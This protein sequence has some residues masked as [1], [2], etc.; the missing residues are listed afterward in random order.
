MQSIRNFH[1][2]GGYDPI[3]RL[4]AA[5][6]RLTPEFYPYDST[7]ELVL[8]ALVLVA[9]A[10][11]KKR[12]WP[13]LLLGLWM[14]A[15]LT[16]GTYSHKHYY[17]P[18]IQ[19]RYYIPAF[20]FLIAVFGITLSRGVEF[21]R[22]RLRPGR[23][24]RALGG[25]A[26]AVF[27]LIPLFHL[28]GV[29][30]KAGRIYR[31]DFVKLT[32]AAIHDANRQQ[33]DQIVVSRQIASRVGQ[34]WYRGLPR[35]DYAER[36]DNV[37][38]SRDLQTVGIDRLLAGGGFHYIEILREIELSVRSGCVQSFDQLLHPALANR[39]AL[40]A[41][42]PD[43]NPRNVVYLDA[44]TFA[45]TE[46]D[47]LGI[48]GVGRYELVPSLT[49]RQDRVYKTRTKEVAHRLT[50]NQM[51]GR[52]YFAKA[53]A[54]IDTYRV[55]VRP[56]SVESEPVRDLLATTT[57]WQVSEDTA[58]ISRSENGRLDITIDD[59]T[60]DAIL[61][62]PEYG[63]GASQHLELPAR[64]RCR[65]KIDLVVTD[66]LT[67]DCVLVIPTGDDTDEQERPLRIRLQN[68]INEIGL[69]TKGAPRHVT[70]TFEVTGQGTV[71]IKS[72]QSQ[73][74]RI[75]PD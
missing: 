59:E 26:A 28:Q 55:N 27:V 12:S 7:A 33:A 41:P 42:P 24:R 45:C 65:L 53:K 74:Q 49:A 22:K 2:D 64:R 58:D 72:M 54:I 37:I 44:L 1:R 57:G 15:Y 36:P 50:N 6:D 60:E 38:M 46:P 11:S 20:P 29:D 5:R 62:T 4:E 48:V 8:L 51:A 19:A 66:G 32:A 68:G 16:W 43:R 31:T 30:H 14:F 47:S 10:L 9:Y 71:T 25:A 40:R 52:R 67:V 73:I 56:V 35:E 63:P 3:K 17:P 23:P 69:Y 13:L 21:F 34:I 18:R 70:P 61:V 39:L 75:Q